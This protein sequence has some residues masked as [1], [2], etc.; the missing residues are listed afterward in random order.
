MRILVI[1][2]LLCQVSSALKHTLR[3]FFTGSHGVIHSPEFLGSAV[4]DDV[5][6][7]Y[8]DSIKNIVE[9]KQEL[10]KYFFEN[11]P[12]HL[13]WYQGECFQNQ[14]IFFKATIQSLMKL[15]NHS[16]GVHVLQRMDGCEWDTA[17]GKVTGY[18]KYGYDA[19]D[20]LSFNMETLKWDALKPEVVSIK[21]SWEAVEPRMTYV[22]TFLTHV[23]PTFMRNYVVHGKSLLERTERPLVSLLQRTPSS[24]VTCHA[25]GFYPDTA[26]LF[27]RKDEEEIHEDVVHGGILPNHDDTFQMKVTLNLSSVA[28]EDWKRYDCV[29]Q[30]SGRSDDIITKLDKENIKTNW[31]SPSKFPAGAAV[32]IT[33]GLL[34]LLVVVFGVVIWRR[35][36]NNVSQPL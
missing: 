9:P 26:A 17:T 33:V 15:Y 35:K 28:P 14:P 19:Q 31:V 22:V 4:L 7:G 30:L 5:L 11:D 8:C 12:E 16:G 34:L 25:S 18:M 27:W 6:M 23:C 21:Q 36:K 20:I 32:G 1:L 13:K 2:F 10:V 29:F 24:P 3:F